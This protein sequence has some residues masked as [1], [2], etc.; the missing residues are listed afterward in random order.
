V[1]RIGPYRIVESGQGST[2]HVYKGY[3]EALNRFVAVK[4]ITG[5]AHDD[6]TL[7]KRFAREAQAAA[8]LTH[9]R[10]VTVYDSG[11]PTVFRRDRG[12]YR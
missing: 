4:T 8:S 12:A 2:S 7:R 6:E 1:E 10:I 11:S 3:D 9:P 5:P